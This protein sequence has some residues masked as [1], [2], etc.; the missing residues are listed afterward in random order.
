MD[1]FHGTNCC[2]QYRRNCQ[3]SKVHK[4]MLLIMS[5]GFQIVEPNYK[6][7]I[8]KR[9]RLRSRLDLTIEHLQ[10]TMS[11]HLCCLREKFVV[12]MKFTSCWLIQESGSN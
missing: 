3:T 9:R 8:K 2:W 4:A 12:F 7:S 5:S 1:D 10:I 6:N 11:K